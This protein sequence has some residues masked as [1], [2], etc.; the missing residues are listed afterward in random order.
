MD[1]FHIGILKNTEQSGPSSKYMR[2][3]LGSLR[4]LP[5]RILNETELSDP[6]SKWILFLSESLTKRT[7]L[8]L[9]AP[10]LQMN[11]FLNRI[12]K[13]TDQSEPGSSRAP[14]E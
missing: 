11:D 13:E 10:E 14:N 3:S 4:E 5:V 9:G 12:L 8:N 6:V 1:D 7:S 2:F